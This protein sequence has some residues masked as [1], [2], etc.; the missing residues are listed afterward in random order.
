MVETMTTTTT[1]Y[2]VTATPSGK[3]WHVE[4]PAINRVTQ[5]KNARDVEVMAKDLISIMT[6]EE[7]PQVSV[8]YA[9]SPEV[10]EHL[11]RVQEARQTEDT[12]RQTAAKEL[13]TAARI[14]R[15]DE[16]LTLSDV[17]AVLGVSHQRA[18]QLVTT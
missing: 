4:V 3:Y 2:Q 17:G 11:R 18:Y 14:L 12:A 1:T 10:S 8:S 6:G 15:D 9:V 7:N 16:H 13:R 5:A